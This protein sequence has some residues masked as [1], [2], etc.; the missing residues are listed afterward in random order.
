MLLRDPDILPLAM[1]HI[2][3]TRPPFFNEMSTVPSLDIILEIRSVKWG[4][5]PTSII[6]ESGFNVVNFLTVF[7]V[8]ISG[9]N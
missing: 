9:F 6:D 3:C 7:S 5:C 2:I 4:S 1:L 8:S